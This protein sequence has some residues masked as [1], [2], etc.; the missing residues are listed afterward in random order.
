MLKTLRCLYSALT[1]C[2][3]NVKVS[4]SYSNFIVVYQKRMSCA[5]S[6][7]QKQRTWIT[8][9][10][11]MK[12]RFFMN[13]ASFSLDSVDRSFRDDRSLSSSHTQQWQPK[14]SHII[15]LFSHMHIKVLIITAVINAVRWSIH[16][17]WARFRI[18]FVFHGLWQ[19]SWINKCTFTALTYT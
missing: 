8:P 19:I 7:S 12:I 1:K 5:G 15:D 11:V 10:Q 3:L 2:H 13:I 4:E 16:D 9:I 14:I 17:T 18:N 6:W